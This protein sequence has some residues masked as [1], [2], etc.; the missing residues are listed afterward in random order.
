M[1][2]G[3]FLFISFPQIHFSHFSFP[4][5]FFQ[6]IFRFQ[7]YPRCILQ[8]HH[9]WWLWKVIR[10]ASIQK[11]CFHHVA[12]Q[13]L[14]NVSRVITASVR[15]HVEDGT[16]NLRFQ[17]HKPYLPHGGTRDLVLI[18]TLVILEEMKSNWYPY[19]VTRQMTN[20]LPLCI[21][22]SLAYTRRAVKPWR[23]FHPKLPPAALFSLSPDAEPRPR[24]YWEQWRPWW[25]RW[26][27]EIYHNP[28]E[29]HGHLG[30]KRT[31][32]K[33]VTPFFDFNSA[34]AVD[35]E[36]SFCHHDFNFSNG[37]F[38]VL[39]VQPVVDLFKHG[40]SVQFWPNSRQLHH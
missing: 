6:N 30:H 20:C 5:F 38:S 13:Q 29:K 16:G 37:L 4:D 39:V 3:P 15:G 24:R 27:P 21:C 35:L 25:G 19:R 36:V 40:P 2:F 26:H 34:P 31:D 9:L 12:N 22:I 7:F 17:M 32:P 28:F 18:R 1:F 14:W 33:C 11:W 8:L 23:A 10:R